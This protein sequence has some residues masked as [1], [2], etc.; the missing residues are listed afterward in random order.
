[1]NT[2]KMIEAKRVYD[3]W[4]KKAY[5]VA[6]ALG[7]GATISGKAPD[8]N[9]VYPDPVITTPNGLRFTF[10]KPPRRERQ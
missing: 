7:E 9:G 4:Y 10:G 3:E 2:E 1:M 8:A 6:L 5:M